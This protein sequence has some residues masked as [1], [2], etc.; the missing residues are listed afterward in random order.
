MSSKNLGVLVAMFALLLA[1]CGSEGPTGS[2]ESV[3][4]SQISCDKSA[5]SVIDTVRHECTATASGAL[6]YHWTLKKNGGAC[7][8]CIVDKAKPSGTFDFGEWIEWNPPGPGEWTIEVL[9]YLSSADHASASGGGWEIHYEYDQ[10]GNVERQHCFSHAEQGRLW[11]KKSIVRNVSAHMKFSFTKHVLESD[12][13]WAR[14]ADAA[15][16]DGDGHMDILGTAESIDVLAWWENSGLKTFDK[17]VIDDDFQSVTS[18]CTEDM[19]N[20]GDLDVIASGD[21]YDTAWW[22]ND[23]L[24][25]FTKRNIDQ[26]NGAEEIRVVDLDADGDLDLV[27]AMQTKDEIAWWENDG[28]Y[29]FTK[30]AIEEDFDF[31]SSVYAADFNADGYVDVVGAAMYGNEIAWWEHSGDGHFTKHVIDADFS[32]PRSVCVIDLDGDNDLDILAASAMTTGELIAC[33]ENDGSNNFTQF[34]VGQGISYAKSVYAIDMD[35]DT[36]VDVVAAADDMEILWWENLGSRNFR[37]NTI[38]SD[39]DGASFVHAADIDGD[40]DVDI[41]GTSKFESVICWWESMM[42]P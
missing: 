20:D 11:Q 9:A 33:L 8:R 40:G 21:H 23:G 16:L 37:K 41:V 42:I 4:I 28:S 30:Q 29:G 36:D 2:G 31:A 22:E 39:F 12:F 13:T 35:N 32:W 24:G 25:H 17:H 1:S 15:D 6:Y 38:D 19:D 27:G 18:V 3:A 26:V 7:S 34:T 5:I 10:Y 14:S